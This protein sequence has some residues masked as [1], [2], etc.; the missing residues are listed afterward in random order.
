LNPHTIYYD[1]LVR[2]EV[3]TMRKVRILSGKRFFVISSLFI[4]AIIGLTS[5]Y[6]ANISEAEK[7]LGVT[8]QMQEGAV[9]FSFPRSDLKVMIDRK[10]VPT[11]L[12]FGS[13]TA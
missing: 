8:G 2:K 7:I 1:K 6:A 10:P 13:W 12:G 5:A 11:A 4:S 9:A 3:E